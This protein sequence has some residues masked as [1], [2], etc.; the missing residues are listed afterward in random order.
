MT[1]AV[2]SGDNRAE[3]AASSDTIMLTERIAAPPEAIFKFLIEP[4][5]MLRWM[6]RSVNIDPRPGG[7]FWLDVTGTDIAAGTYVEID[8]PRRVVFTWGWEGSDDVPPGSSTVTI[9]LT[10]D[11]DDTT[12]ELRHDG[13]AGGAGDAHSEG[14]GYFLPRLQAVATGTD[15]GPDRHTTD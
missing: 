9:T 6:G 5:K 15:P 10:P 3:P 1:D 8:P 7:V 11:G 4:E 13:L 12:V 14:W 2:T